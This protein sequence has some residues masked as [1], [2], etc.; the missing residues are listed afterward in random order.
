MSIIIKSG[1]S[2]DLARV[3]TA[4]Q[5]RVDTGSSSGAFA[6]WATRKGYMRFF[7]PGICVPNKMNTKG[8]IDTPKTIDDSI[9]LYGRKP[10]EQY[11]MYWIYESIVT[12]ST[13]PLRMAL[14]G[15]V[16]WSQ[17]LNDFDPAAWFVQTG[18][19]VVASASHSLTNLVIRTVP[20]EAVRLRVYA[21]S[22]SSNDYYFKFIGV[23]LPYIDDPD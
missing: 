22:G 9:F 11:T 7:S 1:D 18:Y 21:A 5:L 15:N 19:S 13:T 8:W 10:G 12:A 16:T 17:A 20:G 4:G 14:E 3:T 2:G 23:E 6:C